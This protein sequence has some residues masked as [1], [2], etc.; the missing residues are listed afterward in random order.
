MEHLYANA[1]WWFS[2]NSS[3][4]RIMKSLAE[5]ASRVMVQLS[6]FVAF[7][8]K[9]ALLCVLERVPAM[10]GSHLMRQGSDPGKQWSFGKTLLPSSWFVQHIFIYFEPA[11]SWKFIK[12]TC[13]SMS[14]WGL[15]FSTPFAKNS[16]LSSL[17][18]DKKLS[19][20]VHVDT[21]LWMWLPG[22]SL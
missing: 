3:L 10:T 5:C 2:I 13:I 8:C 14:P 22:C 17:K 6:D 12:E 21:V 19:A 20:V 1:C 11:V 15:I 9:T 4:K 18:N 16:S 7:H